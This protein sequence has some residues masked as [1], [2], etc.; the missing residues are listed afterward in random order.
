[1]NSLDIVVYGAN[2]PCPS[3]IH[4][5]S[6]IETKEWIEAAIQRKFPDQSLSVR[7]VDINQP[8]NEK[9]KGFCDRILAEEFFYPLVVIDGEVVGEGDPRIKTIYEAIKNHGFQAAAL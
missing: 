6:S 2:T 4:S 3:C 8:E 7:Y 1:M 9:D 5:P